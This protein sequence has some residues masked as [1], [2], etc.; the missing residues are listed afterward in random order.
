MAAEVWDRFTVHYTPTCQG[1]SK[2]EPPRRSKRGTTSGLPF[3]RG[4]ALGAA[5]GAE[6][7]EAVVGRAFMVDR[8]PRP[9]R[10]AQVP[11]A[12][13]LARSVARFCLLVFTGS[14]C[15][16]F[17]GCERERSQVML[18]VSV[19][20]DIERMPTWPVDSSTLRQF[21]YRNLAL[22]MPILGELSG[23]HEV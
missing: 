9:Q 12:A 3:V 22:G 10:R 20:W 2:R 7:C 8:K 18:P 16:S 4:F 21:T 15:R 1:R 19:Y 5:A 13:Y 17:P 6:P 11:G 14:C 23:L